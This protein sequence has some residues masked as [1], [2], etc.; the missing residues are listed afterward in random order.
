MED[1]DRL[2]EAQRK[3]L[4]AAHRDT[5][6]PAEVISAFPLNDGQ[7]QRLSDALQKALAAPLSCEFREDP[8]VLAGI[9]IHIGS[10]YLQ[11]NLK[12]ELRFFGDVLRNE[13]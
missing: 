7:R 12:E 11:A 10:L 2:P 13:R 4:A 6:A 9:S 3:T 5:Q 1:L 8:A